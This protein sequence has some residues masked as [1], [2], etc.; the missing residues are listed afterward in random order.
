MLAALVTGLI[1]AGALPA[2]AQDPPPD[3]RW[4]TFDTP[5]FQVV[6]HE[7]LD[8]VAA[9]AAERGERAVERLEGF[10]TR[11]DLRI[12]MVVTDHMDLS[13]G[14]ATSI[15]LPRVILWARP[16]LGGLGPIPFDDWLELLV[17]HEVVHVLHGEMTGPLGR[18]GRTVLGRAPLVW[19]L[20]PAFTLPSWA[21]EGVAVQAESALTDGGR[22]HGTRLEGV[23]RAQTLEGRLERIDQVVG[24]T[25]VFPG[26][27]RPYVYG[28]LFHEYLTDRF[29]EAVVGA[30]FRRQAERLNPYRLE[31]TAREIFGHTLS[32][33]HDEWRE[34]V[35]VEAE[36]RARGVDEREL[37]PRPDLLTRNARF[38]LFPRFEPGSGALV[39]VSSDGR[40]ESALIRRAP[41]CDRPRPGDPSVDA[42]GA[43]VSICDEER[44]HPLHL[45][46]PPTPMPDGSWRI[47]QPEFVDRYRVRSDLWALDAGGKRTILTRGARISGVDARPTDGALVAVVE[48]PG[49]HRLV[50]LDP[51]G[52]EIR[53][54]AG[55]DPGVLWTHPRWSPGGEWI[56]IGRWRAGGMWEIVILS[57]EGEERAVVD[58][59]RA[60]ASGP[61]WA[62][63]G[64]WLVW[65]SERTGVANL[66][67]A[68]I[69]GAG[70]ASEVRQLS[71][72]VTDGAFPEVSPDGER[73]VFSWLR[74]G[75]WELA[76]LPFRPDRAFAPLATD[77]R[78]LPAE[79]GAMAE[80]HL[81]ALEIEPRPW[82]PLPTL[83]PRYVV[84]FVHG[85][86]SLTSGAGESVRVLPAVLGL[87]M[88]ATDVVGRHRWEARVGGPV[89]GEVRR[90]EG[91]ARWSWAGLGNPVLTGTAEQRWQPLGR[92]IVLREGES[93]EEGR[94]LLV[95]AR[96]RAAGLRM[97]AVH[98][99]FRGGRSAGLE[100]RGVRQDR[101]FLT[102]DGALTREGPFP[103]IRRDLVD[104]S[105]TLGLSRVRAFPL[106]VGPQEGL[107]IVTR[108]R[109]RRETSLPAGAAGV[110]GRDGAL[111]DWVGVARYFQPLPFGG[112]ARGETGSAVLG[113]RAVGGMARGPGAGTGHFSVGG[114]GDRLFP[115]R[116]TTAGARGGTRAWAASAEVRLPL[117]RVHRGWGLLPLHLDQLA[118][119]VFLDAGAAPAGGRNPDPIASAGVELVLQQTALFQGSERLRVGVAAPFVGASGL[120]AYAALGWSF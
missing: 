102:P 41:G 54:L 4:Y 43:E 120:A 93:V 103:R 27:E 79:P 31:A 39:Y 47:A 113:L 16:P 1:L 72:L 40:T 18:L 96:E 46:S 82:S 70:R 109:V 21:I 67:V 115:V 7:G 108:V 32:Q 51:A 76:G 9:R 112:G 83:R 19:P 61:A 10:G 30:F 5:H 87:S 20:F 86:E 118:G 11:P 63:D 106:S 53:E 99:G 56:A 101:A 34:T 6:F 57:A 117:A 80:G 42:S 119:S 84:P 75:G 15:P 59:G 17:T 88:G 77:P 85:P 37:A 12:Q 65:S 114:M 90:W 28:A 58:R 35:L 105:V 36:S 2:V 107:S 13:N 104:A 116:G 22:I 81:A 91:L 100:L 68:A 98:P 49:T 45:L 110:A 33:L 52:V 71:D 26:G 69:D 48:V 92:V 111:E 25:G 38:A 29:G 44:L 55:P 3:L 78:F 8:E 66:F 73:I 23:V 60:P 74:A 94:E 64:D 97:D 95:T 50:L 89:G 62:P 24:T 14:F